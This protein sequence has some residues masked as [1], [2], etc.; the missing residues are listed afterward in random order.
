MP[1]GVKLGQLCLPQ[2][3]G[4]AGA[5]LGPRPDRTQVS[6]PL[7]LTLPLRELLSDWTTLSTMSQNIT[8]LGS[9]FGLEMSNWVHWYSSASRFLSAVF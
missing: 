2:G 6:C 3:A 9:S 4:E 5:P 1:W 8:P 7:F